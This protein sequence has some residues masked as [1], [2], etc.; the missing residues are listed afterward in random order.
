MTDKY[1]SGY[2]RSHALLPANGREIA[3]L[4]LV[5]VVRPLLLPIKAES[6]NIVHSGDA[7]QNGGLKMAYKMRPTN[8]LLNR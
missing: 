4:G 6:K 5:M 3:T 8:I 1:R 7:E 2:N